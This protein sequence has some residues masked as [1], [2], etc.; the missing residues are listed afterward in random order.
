MPHRLEIALNA[1]MH[2]AEGEGIRKKA[3]DYFGIQLDEVRVVQILTIDADMSND[4]L[5]A[6]QTQIFTNPV[7]QISSYQSLSVPF[8]W[9]I[10]GKVGDPMGWFKAFKIS[11]A[12]CARQGICFM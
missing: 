7:T 5:E 4:Q 3:E 1:D 10:S 6:I 8:D 11:S 9:M 12:E 2:D